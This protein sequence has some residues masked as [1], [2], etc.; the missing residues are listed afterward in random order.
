VIILDTDHLSILQDNLAREHATLVARMTASTDQD[1]A[2]TVVTVEEQLRGWLAFL[3][4]SNDVANQVTPYD[5]LIGLVQFFS[6]WT[7]LR[8]DD[9]C[10][11]Q[12][13]QLR[14][15]KVRIGS[16]D[17][18]IAAIALVEKAML[19]SAKLRDFQQ[20]P[21]LQVEDWLH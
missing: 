8:F 13:K 1:F 11:D 3:N 6:R 9:P 18:K 5:R 7:V 17:L 14:N 20:V 12:F 21:N 19:V 2:V 10:A 16:M 15:Q 4:R